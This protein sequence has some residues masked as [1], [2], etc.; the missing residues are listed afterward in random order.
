MAKFSGRKAS[1]ARK[2]DGKGLRHNQDK[3]RWDLL[4]L[5]AVEQ[6]VKVLTAGARKYAE[7]NWER[8]MKFG[9]CQASMMR[10][11]VKSSR[12]E[13]FDEESGLPHMAHAACNALFLLAYE[14][15]GLDHLDNREPF[16]RAARRK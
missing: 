13:K 14:L 9:I 3:D 4:P 8:G 1:G 7:H 10:H 11:I 16:L 6:V 15:R 5:D 2:P 12:G